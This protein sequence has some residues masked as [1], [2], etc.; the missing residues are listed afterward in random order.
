MKDGKIYEK[1]IDSNSPP[2]DTPVFSP[3]ADKIAYIINED[4]QGVVIV[5][6][7]SGK[8]EAKYGPYNFSVEYLTFSPDGKII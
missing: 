6:D 8:L 1:E 7:L 5:E 2:F 4:E 3:N